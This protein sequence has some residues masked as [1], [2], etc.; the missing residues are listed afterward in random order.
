M[1][2]LLRHHQSWV[3][4]VVKLIFLRRQRC[5]LWMLLILCVE[6]SWY[7]AIKREVINA[8]WGIW[9][10]WYYLLKTFSCWSKSVHIYRSSRLDPMSSLD[11]YRSR[12]IKYYSTTSNAHAIASDAILIPSHYS[13]SPIVMQN[14]MTIENL[15]WI[16]TLIFKMSNCSTMK[17]HLMSSD[18]NEDYNSYNSSSEYSSSHRDTYQ[19]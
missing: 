1:Q 13:S 9:L 7:C 18:E 4:W 3:V 14:D 16:A 15:I 8:M 17:T 10:Q 6:I 2:F 12:N 11:K 19:C 5:C